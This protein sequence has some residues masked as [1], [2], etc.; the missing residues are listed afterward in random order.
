MAPSISKGTDMSDYELHRKRAARMR[1]K[2]MAAFLQTAGGKVAQ[3]AHAASVKF[4]EAAGVKIRLL[5]RPA[6]VDQ[7]T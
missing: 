6:A 4:Y 7:Q 2:V 1:A 5:R 3:V